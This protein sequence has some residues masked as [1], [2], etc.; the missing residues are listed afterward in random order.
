MKKRNRARSSSLFLLELIIAILFF[1]IASAVCVQFFVKSHSMSQASQDLN[2]A[3][4]ECISIAETVQTSDSEKAAVSEVKK[5]Y[6]DA[7]ITESDNFTT[8]SIYFDRNYNP[9][10]S[11]DEDFSYYIEADFETS[12]GMITC[13]LI[14]TEADN[15]NAIYE[16]EVKHNAQSK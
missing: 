8:C 12:K 14:A 7:K 11:F 10:D 16:L 15:E 4:S 13:N 5:A 6:P 1:S 9:C 3:V 2:F